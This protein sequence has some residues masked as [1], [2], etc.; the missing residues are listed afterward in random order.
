MKID[1]TMIYNPHTKKWYKNGKGKPYKIVD[2]CKHCGNQYMTRIDK[3][4]EY[5]CYSCARSGENNP[6]FGKTHSEQ[7]KVLCGKRLK[8]INEKLKKEKGV[9]NISQLPEIKMKKHQTILSFEYIANYVEQYGYKLLAKDRLTNKHT[10]LKLECPNG[11]IIN[12]R[13]ESFKSGHRCSQCFYDELKTKFTEEELQA[14]ENYKKHIRQ[15]TEQTYTEYKSII[16]P[17]NFKRNK[18]DYH[19]DHKFSIIEG[20]KQNI[21]PKIMASVVNLEMITAF[22]NLSKGSNC[23][24]TKQDLFN[25]YALLENK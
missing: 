4:S 6:M 25:S 7:V 1:E 16:N 9:D 24:I 13:Y 18:K 3:P 23:S 17:N 15:L 10:I 12:M 22:D 20:F 2:H 19:L 11:H 14:F 8:E 5:C 21:D